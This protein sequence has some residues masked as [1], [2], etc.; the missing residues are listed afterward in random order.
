MT[1]AKCYAFAVG[2]MRLT[3]LSHLLNEF[4]IAPIPHVFSDSQLPIVRINNRIY[5]RVAVAHMVTKY[6]L[7]ADLSRD[8]E[9]DLH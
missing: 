5:G 8:G 3:Q 4:C 6:Y 9:F 2:C 1:D 7:A